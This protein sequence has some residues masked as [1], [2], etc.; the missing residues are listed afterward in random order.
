[1][2]N[3]FVFE[4]CGFWADGMY[5]EVWNEVNDKVKHSC[6]SVEDAMIYSLDAAG[7]IPL[8]R[9]GEIPLEYFEMDEAELHDLC[10][11]LGVDVR[12]DLSQEY[13]PN[14]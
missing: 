2:A 7:V 8:N 12:I 13:S 6:H 1:M 10:E 4:D 3:L 9:E 14:E 5:F 11:K